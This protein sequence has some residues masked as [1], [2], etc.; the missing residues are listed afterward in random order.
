MGHTDFVNKS[1]GEKS[2]VALKQK[3]AQEA[4]AQG[5]PEESPV[6]VSQSNGE[7]EAAVKEVKAM[8]RT[9]KSALGTNLVKQLDRRDPVWRGSQS[10]P[11]T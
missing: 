10:T 2:L 6:G 9:I 4:G 7:A 11:P 8:V 5:M 1:G 3:A